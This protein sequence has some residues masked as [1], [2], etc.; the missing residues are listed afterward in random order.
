MEEIYFSSAIPYILVSIS[1]ALLSC[2]DKYFDN[3]DKVDNGFFSYFIVL[4]TLF[5]PIL[6]TLLNM[7]VLL[8]YSLS[9][10]NKS[11][12]VYFSSLIIHTFFFISL[13]AFILFSIRK[14]YL[15][16]VPLAIEC[17]L[18]LTEE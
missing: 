6:T 14:I 9:S 5:F 12:L 18:S 11:N 7:I 13:I 15:L 3:L 2:I 17:I 10:E 4:M 8:Y 1:I 16:L